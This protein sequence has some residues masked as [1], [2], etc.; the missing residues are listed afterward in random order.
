M[1]RVRKENP[2]ARVLVVGTVASVLPSALEGLGVT[3]VKGEAEQLYWKLDEVL[4]HSGAA[5]SLGTLE[6]LDAIPLPDWTV[7]QPQRFRI[8]HDFWRFPTGLVQSS[9]GC[10]FKCNYCPYI[11]LENS[12]RFRDPEAVVAEIGL[13]IRR[14]GFR[15]FK[16][17]DPLFGLNRDHVFRLAELL[18]RLPQRIQFSVESRI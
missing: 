18:A 11:I 5:I 15:S 7:F 10:T 8:G 3:V 4:G 16:F 9:R 13:G 6:D 14:W 12:T 2:R 1:A 17:R